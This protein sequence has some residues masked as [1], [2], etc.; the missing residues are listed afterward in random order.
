M[1]TLTF[2]DL[3]YAA[4][5]RIPEGQTA[6]YGD[7]AKIIGR[8]NAAR[9]VGTALHYNPYEW[10]NE[11]NPRELWVPCHRVTAKDG[12][13]ACNFGFGGAEEQKVRLELEGVKIIKTQSGYKVSQG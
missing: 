2:K 3:V 7:I 4:V 12:S 10:G 1:S 9:A 13:L 6:S 5:R 8:P 11:K